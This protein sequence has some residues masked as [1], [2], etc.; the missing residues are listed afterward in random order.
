MTTDPGPVPDDPTDVPT[1][2][3]LLTATQLVEVDGT[4]FVLCDV[5]TVAQT[6]ASFP[7][8]VRDGVTSPE[9]AL[10]AMNDLAHRLIALATGLIQLAD[11]EGDPR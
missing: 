7:E 11:T 8:A 10:I 9:V 1:D 5:S 2:H 4:T 6:L 3:P